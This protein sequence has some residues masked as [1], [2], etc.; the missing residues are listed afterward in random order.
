MEKE[1][2]KITQEEIK[3]IEEKA[4]KIR[5][6]IIEE[7]YSHQ[8]GHPGGS[9]SVADI[10][11]VLYFKEMNINPQEPE[12]KER[13]RLVLSKGHCAPALYAALANRGYFKTE[14]LKTFRS[15]EGRLQG[16]PDKKNIPG[17]DMS[18]GSLGQGL[19][20]ANGMA[21]AGKLDKKEYRVYC[22]LG[23][24]ELE[25]GQIW[26]A[27]MT[28][29]KNKL[30][31]LC[32]IVDNNNLQIDGTIQEV[33]NLYQIDEKFKSFGFEVIKIDGHNIEE[34]IK[35]LEKAKTIKEK[36]TCII[37]K[38]IKGKGI[39]YME[40]QAGW[41]GKAPNQEQYLEAVKELK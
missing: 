32:V 5:K 33:K 20:N 2:K 25:E 13:D 15:I 30:D 22:I 18:T 3:A 37:A 38:T 36:P 21:I 10:I 31:N 12:W 6:G 28:S 4:K 39:S 23:D 24:G 26:E 7:V 35:A 40:N 16:H 17:V 34:M 11:A 41:H 14:E 29:S 27:A 9:L 1:N 8:S 19:S